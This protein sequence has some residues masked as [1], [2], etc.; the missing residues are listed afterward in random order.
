MENEAC[1]RCERTNNEVKLVDAIYNG[2][3]VKICEECALTEDLPIIRR[4]SS[5][6]LKESDKPYSVRD[7]MKRMAGMN[8]K[9]EPAEFKASEI[10][11]DKLRKPK[12]YEAVLAN[13]FS[14]AKEKNQ[15]LNLV[16]NYHWLVMMTRKNRKMSRKQLADSIGESETTIKLL[17]ENF[18]PDD[19]LRI[20]AKIE[21]YL[22]IRL[23]KDN[24]PINIEFKP[25]PARIIKIDDKLAKN[26]TIDDL[27]RMKKAREQADDSKI[28][29]E[30]NVSEFIWKAKKD[31]KVI[32]KE[33]VE[34]K[35]LVG[36][37]VEFE[38]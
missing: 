33:I 19:G 15:P 25:I 32:P 24:A 31:E 38:E 34:D 35:E 21:Q 13:R 8:Q 14:Q 12:D 1:F 10:T 36:S 5:Q 20:I 17:E 16:D 23:R 27:R 29:K 28:K 4:P 6:Q 3:I 7:R 22:G 9:Q 30:I 18:L 11:L 37:D 2:E 26:I